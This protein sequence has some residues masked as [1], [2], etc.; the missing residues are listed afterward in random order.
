MDISDT[1]Q[2]VVAEDKNS[3]HKDPAFIALR[4]FYFEMQKKGIATKQAYN[5]PTLDLVGRSLVEPA[6]SRPRNRS[7]P[8]NS[9]ANSL[10]NH[11]R[12][13]VYV[14]ATFAAESSHLFTA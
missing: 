2:K 5:I 7:T 9:A 13:E 12:A 3:F 6:E 1:I 11:I 8:S 14:L 4:E 10:S